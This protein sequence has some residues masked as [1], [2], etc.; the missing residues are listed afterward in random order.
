MWHLLNFSPRIQTPRARLGGWLRRPWPGRLA[1][2]MPGQPKVLQVTMCWQHVSKGPG[3][4]EF[5]FVFV[6]KHAAQL[7]S[8]LPQ[9]PYRDSIW[10]FSRLGHVQDQEWETHM[11]QWNQ[12]DIEIHNNS[13][14]QINHTISAVNSTWP[15]TCLAWNHSW[16]NW[17]KLPKYQ[18]ILRTSAD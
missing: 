15:Q 13:F 6:C 11:H 4:A 7:I 16:C 1:H 2:A 5:V 14:E 8:Q 3:P 17:T 10:V 12:Q 9:P 18:A